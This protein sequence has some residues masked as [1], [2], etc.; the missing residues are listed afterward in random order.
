MGL[1]HQAV[2]ENEGLWVAVLPLLSRVRR[3]T[4]TKPLPNLVA[5]WRANFSWRERMP[6][7]A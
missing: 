6:I 7:T 2:V 4:A 3:K 1:A 5:I